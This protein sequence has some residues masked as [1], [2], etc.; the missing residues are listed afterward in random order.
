MNHRQRLLQLIRERALI[1]GQV[2]LSSGQ[3]SDFYV[4]GKMIELHPEGAHLIGETLYELIRDLPVD[5]VGGLA[6]G[7]VPVVT[8]LVISCFHH[9]HSVEGFFVREEAK[10]HGTMKTIEGRLPAGAGVVLVDDVITS[11][12]SVLKAAQ[13]AQQQRQATILGV[14]ALVDRDAGAR[15]L[16]ESL[17]YR[18]ETVFTR[19]DVLEGAP[20]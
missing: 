5:A 2:T 15:Q 12:K 6:V 18:Y 7:A 19:H 17:G 1:Q 16:F 8:S 4:D 3:T 13:A 20:G 10:S 14:V 11:G 9:R